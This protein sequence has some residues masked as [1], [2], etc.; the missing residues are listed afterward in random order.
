MMEL[1]NDKLIDLFAKPGTSDEDKME[2][3]K[4][5]KG[6][7]FVNGA[8]VKTAKDSKELN[9]LFEQ[10][11]SN[12]HVAST[13]MNSESSRSHLILSV[14]IESTNRATGNVMKGKLSLVD[15]AG[16]ERVGK[17]GATAE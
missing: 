2:I 4:D 13:K 14:V 17:T 12:R 8:I 1:Y 10:G 15:L 3:K 7:V 11:S 9:T 5:K 6:L 16:S